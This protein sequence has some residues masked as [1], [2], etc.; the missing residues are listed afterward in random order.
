MSRLK[1]NIT[2]IWEAEMTTLGERIKG[3]RQERN[4]TQQSFAESISVSRPFISR[5]E[6]NKETPSDS[7]LKLIAA[8]Y[9]IKYE[10]LK[11]GLE[12]KNSP[13][14]PYRDEKKE[15]ANDQ[16][17]LNISEPGFFQDYAFCVSVLVS[18]LKN[19]SIEDNSKKYY[20]ESIKMILVSIERFVNGYKKEMESYPNIMGEDTT[21][22]EYVKM[23]EKDCL[24]N[25]RTHL[26]DAIRTM[27]CDNLD[28][29]LVE[30]NF[31][32]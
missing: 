1:C 20:I 21:W 5:I 3:I 31:E 11:Y 27:V 24:E 7:L 19:N 9:D 26:E 12:P 23:A 6:S 25:I 4:L 10:W 29:E 14:V 13:Q 15:L 2:N 30:N 28:A 17:L 22:F 32:Y 18:M 16:I 8:T